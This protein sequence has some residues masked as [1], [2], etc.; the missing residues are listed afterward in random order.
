MFLDNQTQQPL[1]SF[2]TTS[3]LDS[4]CVCAR[5]RARVYN[6]IAYACSR[7]RS[8]NASQLVPTPSKSPTSKSL[9]VRVQIG[10]TGAT[11]SGPTLVE[12]SFRRDDF[13][14][15]DFGRGEF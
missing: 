14:W 13:V 1:C 10:L 8:M 9:R 11:L 5:A 3:Q 4:A 15:G 2:L 7:R 6:V 12:A